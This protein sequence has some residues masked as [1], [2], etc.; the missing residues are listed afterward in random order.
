MVDPHASSRVSPPLNEGVHCPNCGYDLRGLPAGRCPECGFGFEPEAIAAQVRDVIDAHHLQ[1]DRAR[2]G[3]VLAGAGGLLSLLCRSW[4]TLPCGVLSALAWMVLW[5][6]QPESLLCR[7]GFEA[8]RMFALLASVLIGLV[9]L[10][11]FFLPGLTLVPALWALLVLVFA[12]PEQN[13]HLWASVDAATRS[14]LR[15]QKRLAWVVWGLGSSA[16]GLATL[17]RIFG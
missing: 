13:R 9:V 15:A 12:A 4:T 16:A 5:L 3:S 14:D 1:L 8:R 6:L 2:V 17:L 11:A 7:L 10:A